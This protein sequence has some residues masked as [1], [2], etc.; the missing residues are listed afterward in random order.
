MSAPG[1]ASP[2]GVLG[3]LLAVRWRKWFRALH[4]DVGYVA[5]ALTLAYGLSGIAVNHIEDWNP[6]YTLDERAI[7]LGPIPAGDL[8]AQSA[9]VIDKLQIPASRVNGQ[10]YESAHELRV[11]LEGGSEARVML[12]TGKGTYSALARRHVF[13]EVNKL[14][15]N[16]LK[17][18]W[19]Y[20]ADAFAV[21]L[22]FLA[23]TGLFMMKGAHGLARR[24]KWFVL[25]GLSVPVAF[26]IYL[27]AGP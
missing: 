18:V 2:R 3:V 9:F 16:E 1:E 23:L 19:T 11:L 14:H 4:R 22:I 26:V 10:I 20:V 8:A 21:A 6:N 7:D 17:G 27:Y 5:V 12:A 25:A 24:G 15:L 13:F